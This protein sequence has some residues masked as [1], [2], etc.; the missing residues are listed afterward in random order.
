MR[1]LKQL[2]IQVL[3]GIALGVAL[4]LVAPDA[5]LLMKPLGDAFI[6][7]LRMMLGPI[8]FC[9]VVLGLTHVADMRQLGRLAGKSL[10]YFE[11]VSTL[12]MAIGL[13]AVNLLEPGVGLHAGATPVA[14]VDVTNQD[15][16]FGSPQL[17]AS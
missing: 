2:Y 5:A 12:A 13:V 3:I 8:I 16:V 4:G 7:L 6:A 11:V 9:S 17:G 15:V 1:L 10:L 14:G